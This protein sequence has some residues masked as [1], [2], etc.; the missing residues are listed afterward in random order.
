MKVSFFHDSRLKYDAEKNRY[1]TSGG[2]TND[3]LQRYMEFFESIT[4]VTRMENLT[5]ADDISKLSE[6]SGKGINFKCVS[7]MSI[8]SLIN[9]SMR[10]RIRSI[11]EETDFAIIRLP[12]FIGIIACME[13]N[14]LKKPYLIEMVA[15]PFCAL[16][17][18]GKIHYKFIAPFYALANK[19]LIK[20]AKNVIYVTREYLQ[21]NYPNYNNSIG[22]SD[23]VIRP[24]VRSI[25]Q[26]KYDRIDSYTNRTIYQIGL[27]G[28]MNVKFKGHDIAIKSASILRKKGIRV[29]LH[30]LG[31]CNE[32]NKKRLTR[33]ATVEKVADA[34]VID[35]TLPGGDAVNEWIDKK[36]F[37]ILPSKAE[38]LPRSLIEAMNRASI[39]IGTTAG[40]IPELLDS[41]CIMKKNNAESLAHIIER[42]ANNK[43]RMK[44]ITKRNAIFSREYC[45]KVLANK[46]KAF[47]SDMLTKRNDKVKV[48][49]VIGAMNMGGAETML[50][51]I[52]QTI[53]RK[54]F[55]MS[56]LCYSFD[57]FDYEDRIYSLGG[58]IIRM[59][60]RGILRNIVNIR[61]LIK[62]NDIDIVHC[63]TYYNSVFPVVAAKMLK[64]KKI[65][66]H[67]H[68]TQDIKE[69]RFIKKMYY[70]ISRRIINKYADYYMACG[71][72][73]GESLFDN[74]RKT[75]ILHNGIILDNYKFSNKNRKLMRDELGI[76]DNK[77]VIGHIG[78]FVSAKNHTF[79]LDIFSE[80]CKKN[81]DIV[82]VLVGEGTLL[83]DMKQKARNL[84]ISS[85]VIFLGLRNDNIRLYSA[86]DVMIFPS[87]YEGVPLTLIEAQMNGLPILA[88]DTID[89][90]VNVTGEIKFLSL[91]KSAE[92]W[93]DAVEKIDKK[94]YVSENNMYNSAYN[95]INEVKRLEKI[96]EK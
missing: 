6:S 8:K 33:L 95:M 30:F 27:I 29:E 66:V 69:G 60:Q 4:M 57:R 16:W 44:D 58:R 65:I 2:L 34:V 19:W 51:N 63:H 89:S 84:G 36:D 72:K 10:K 31:K 83:K 9:G 21:R 45:H 55:D 79:L 43:E 7:N 5:N 56:F 70:S 47:F 59:K 86:M 81:K 67:S 78:R 73:A 90:S 87:L 40:G 93:V 39:C 62:S 85:K 46:R 71:E 35:G 11:L 32:N 76:G 82:L 42:L 80:Y 52:L 15:S 68:S 17:Y 22:I 94:R 49:N 74:K 50:M 24:T 1:Y 3:Y 38:G 23:V 48:L 92:E 61:N 20:K 12:S 37:I 28:S 91:A 13:C 41:D 25:L 64:N 77:L 96:Y 18:Y 53:D 26:K 88:S 54:R 75:V 14:K